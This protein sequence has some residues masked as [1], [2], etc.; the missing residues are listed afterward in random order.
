MAGS[1]C[2]GPECACAMW[3]KAG[4][5]RCPGELLKLMKE[6]G[7]N[8]DRPDWDAGDVP[9]VG[10]GVRHQSPFESPTAIQMGYMDFLRRQWEELKRNSLPEIVIPVELVETAL[11]QGASGWELA[12]WVAAAAVIGAAGVL[13]GP[14]AARGV[15][16]L[17]PKPGGPSTRGVSQAFPGGRGV[18]PKFGRGGYGGYFFPSVLDEK[19]LG[20]GGARS[21][22]SVAFFPGPLG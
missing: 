11:D 6:R 16:A 3:K 19:W 5:S 18:A 14:G 4:L 7:L 17:V 8:R 13:Y 9:D 15:A 22:S 1:S 2:G 10:S 20:R 12:G 21:R